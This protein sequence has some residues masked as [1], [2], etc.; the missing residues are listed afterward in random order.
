MAKGRRGNNEGT[1]FE[2]K[3]T[4]TLKD[5]TT[6]VLTKWYGEI[7]IGT[8]AQGKRQVLRE[9]ADKRA[10]VQAWMIEQ[11]AE[12]EETGRLTEPSKQTLGNFLDDWLTKI[13]AHT[14]KRTTHFNYTGI[15]TRYLV[16]GLGHIQLS[17]LTPDHLVDLYHNLRKKGLRAK[18]GLSEQT[19]RHVHAVLHAALKSAK[20]RGLVKLNVADHVEAPEVPKY[21]HTVLTTQQAQKFLTVAKQDRLYPLFVVLIQCGL[22]IGEALALRWSDLDFENGTLNVAQRVANLSGTL[23]FDEPKS[24]T[25]RRTFDL[26]ANVITVL[27]HWRS[28]QA[29]ERLQCKG[30]WHHPELTFTTPIGTVLNVNNIRNRCLNPLLKAAGLPHVRIH[31]LRHTALSVM[32]A[33]GMTPKE[34]QEA[35]GHEDITTTYNIYGHL[36]REQKKASAKRLDAFWT[37][38]G[39]AK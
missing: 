7:I 5:G 19:V 32:A 25:S 12:R 22:R 34:V 16:P 28:V 14:K 15:V 18:D 9:T 27:K 29:Q 6:K 4:I 35:A 39:K 1:I 30:S 10:T 17:K 3:R 2:R 24:E 13:V 21:K 33:S 38:A 36:F 8:D 26:P 11:L 23:D 37:A 31:D 20:K